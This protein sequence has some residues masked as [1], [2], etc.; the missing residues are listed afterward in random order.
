MISNRST[1][2]AQLPE[3]RV[4]RDVRRMTESGFDEIVELGSRY[5]ASVSATAR[6]FIKLHRDP[7]AIVIN[8]QMVVE[9]I[10]R[11][12]GFT[13]VALQRGH[14]VHHKAT[15]A[16]FAGTAREMSVMDVVEPSYWLEPTRQFSQE[17]YEQV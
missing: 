15:T 13:Y 1:A 4:A 2:A 11:E 6:R 14:S 10:Y 16:R 3:S 17:L 12:H 8:N 9:Q 7:T 5:Q